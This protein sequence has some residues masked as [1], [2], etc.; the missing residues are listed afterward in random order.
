MWSDFDFLFRLLMLASA[1]A[2]LLSL[3]GIYAVMSFA[4]SRQTRE[5]GIRVA[6]GADAV[7][8]V[9]ST[10]ARPLTQVVSGIGAGSVLVAIASALV[11][12]GLSAREMALVATYSLAMTAVC[13]LACIVPTMRALRIEPT[14]ALRTD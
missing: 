8:V 13:M 2:L 6:L 4:V 10:F 12:E 5:I 7:R 14:E 11:L 3:A 9:A 1:I